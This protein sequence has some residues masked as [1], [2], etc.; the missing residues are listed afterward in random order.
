MKS[1]FMTASYI[2]QL[3]G[4]VHR[5]DDDYR[6]A[7]YTSNDGLNLSTIEYTELGE[8][9]GLGYK[10]GGFL[11]DSPTIT[12]V[13]DGA[14]LSFH[15]FRRD[16]ASIEAR[17]AMIYNETKNNA[18]VAL[19]DFGEMVRSQNGPYTIPLSKGPLSINMRHI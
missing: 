14:S 1:A 19:Y 12:I 13:D 4:G 9:F 2:A 10:K 8:T 6:I 17:Y 7:L 5:L 11:L 15:D 18:S 3:F 16:V